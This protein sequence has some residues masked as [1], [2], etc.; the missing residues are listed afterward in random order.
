MSFR[1]GDFDRSLFKAKWMQKPKKM[2]TSKPFQSISGRVIQDLLQQISK[3][4]P[5]RS[6]LA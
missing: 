4:W 5:S 1:W 6:S 3:T 2:V